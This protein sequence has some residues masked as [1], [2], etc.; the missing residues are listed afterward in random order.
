M[1]LIRSRAVFTRAGAMR[2]LACGRGCS[3][4]MHSVS[5]CKRAARPGTLLGGG[6]K[7]ILDKR[8]KLQEV[9]LDKAVLLSFTATA[10][11]GTQ[12]KVLAVAMPPM[13]P[14]LSLATFPQTAEDDI[15]SHPTVVK[16]VPTKNGCPTQK[17][18]GLSPG[19]WQKCMDNECTRK[20]FVF[21]IP[22]P[23]L[24][25]G[26]V[27]RHVQCQYVPQL[28]PA[29]TTNSAGLT[30]AYCKKTFETVEQYKAS[31]AVDSA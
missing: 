4:V 26:V 17:F 25:S 19:V 10:G 30:C 11:D 29:Y 23:K 24:L 9:S 14:G 7:A 22:R 2:W 15:L 8:A 28:P 1:R 18:M 16:M 21:T 13:I 3:G 20:R 6:F 31:C 12:M 5:K 27:V